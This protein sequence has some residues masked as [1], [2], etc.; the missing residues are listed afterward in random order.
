MQ[1]V[2][3]RLRA[4]REQPLS[5]YEAAPVASQKNSPFSPI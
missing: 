5:K 3:T 2:K 1:A 4:K